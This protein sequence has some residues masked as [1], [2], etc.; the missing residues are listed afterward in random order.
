MS[1]T[2]SFFP[3]SSNLGHGVPSTFSPS[4]YWNQPT[5]GGSNYAY[6]PS[7][8]SQWIPPR[9]LFSPASL[10]S[11]VRSNSSPAVP[12]EGTQ[13]GEVQLPPFSSTLPGM[14][15]A[16][17]QHA[18]SMGMNSQGNNGNPQPTPIHMQESYGALRPPPTP[19]Y[20]NQGSSTNSPS[21][22]SFPF[23]SGPSPPIVSPLGSGGQQQQQHQHQPRMPPHGEMP[24]LHQ[25]TSD[26]TGQFSR[27]YGQ[28]S[29]PAMS[30]PAMSN[31]HSPNGQMSLVGNMS[32]PMMGGFN[33]GHAAN[34]QQMYAMPLMGP[35]SA[36]SND[37]PFKC[38][39]CVQSFNRNH[40][41]KRHKRIHLA[42]KPFPCGHCDKSF[43]RK[44]A[45]K[46]C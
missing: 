41:L 18:M 20:F 10:N 14:T 30:G 19:T 39:Q 27:P 1:P 6:Q 5:P 17:Q 46:V 26:P 16:Q 31:L 23:S 3:N 32:N 34:M 4:G 43:S 40:D 44:D 28:Y 33:S 2:P 21:Q 12:T 25:T 9:G 36:P 37:R 45:L 8:N 11:F 24:R 7:S 13:Y 42:V 22:N 15:N 38:D 35:A 29:L